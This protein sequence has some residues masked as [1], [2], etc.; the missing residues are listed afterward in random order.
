MA[1][2]NAMQIPPSSLSN[3]QQSADWDVEGI[4]G[5]DEIP[6]GLNSAMD[7]FAEGFESA[8]REAEAAKTVTS[9]SPSTS[10]W[11]LDDADW[12]VSE[13]VARVDKEVAEE[14]QPEQPAEAEEVAAE[15]NEEAASE[16]ASIE[17][18]PLVDEAPAAPESPRSASTPEPEAVTSDDLLS[19][20]AAAEREC[21]RAGAVVE[22]LKARSKEAKQDYEAAVNKLRRL[23]REVANDSERP[24]IPSPSKAIAATSDGKLGLIDDEEADTDDDDASL[25]DDEVNTEIEPSADSS[26]SQPQFTIGKAIRIRITKDDPEHPQ[27]PVGS[28]HDIIDFEEGEEGVINIHDPADETKE[29]MLD[30]TEYE[31][32]AW[33]ELPVTIPINQATDPNSAAASQAK[34]NEKNSRPEDES[35]RKASLLDD[36]G[37]PPNLAALLEGNPGKTLKTMGDVSDWTGKG[38]NLNDI[39]KIGP[40]KVTQIEEAFEKFWARWNAK[41]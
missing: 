34:A 14:Q 25:L 11:N 4:D 21:E 23:A 31:I 36:V 37:L 12:D 17:T 3:Q 5:A 27:I 22:A 16:E 2:L 41:K 33:E 1:T 18:S 8:E 20:I 30:P 6:A 15:L 38:N 10:E 7:G 19:D 28:E 26:D 35:W 32:I 39:P 24:M 40:A 13:P 29:L 9:S